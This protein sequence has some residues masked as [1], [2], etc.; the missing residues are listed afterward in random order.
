MIDEVYDTGGFVP[1]LPARMWL[2][3]SEA[4]YMSES[5]TRRCCLIVEDQALVAMSLEAYLEEQG[6]EVCGPVP[7]CVEAFRWLEN[8]APELA[9]VD[10]NLQDGPATDLALELR[11]RGI[12]FI[13]YSGDP[14]RPDLPPELQD[15]PWLEK[16]IARIGLLNALAGLHVS[17]DTRTSSPSQRS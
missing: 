4:V 7:S 1:S 6:L 3:Q 10:F 9:I 16:P 8:S 15:V 2:E 11:R 12:P 13:I 17:G 14:R 5:P